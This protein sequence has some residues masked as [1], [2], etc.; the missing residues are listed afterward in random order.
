MVRTIR[1]KER[2]H[3]LEGL[4][5]NNPFLTDD[6]LAEA[7][8][9]SIQT[10]R[11]DRL[12]LGIPELRERVKLLAE[13]AESKLKSI[14]DGELVGELLDLELGL[15]AISVLEVGPEMVLQ[16]ARAARGHHL[17]AQANSLAVAVINAEVALTAT[18]Q[19]KFKRPVGLGEKVVAKAQVTGRKGNRSLVAVH[20][21]VN[22]EEVF[23]GRFVI[24]A[25]GLEGEFTDAHS[26]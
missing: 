4:L 15:R 23:T 16:K 18:A 6:E 17:F 10:V 25:K 20:S 19:V 9:V 8:L 11:L 7:L 5:N 1:K 22:G 12:E 21:T 26:C 14:S 13:R 24:F 3:R 2:Q